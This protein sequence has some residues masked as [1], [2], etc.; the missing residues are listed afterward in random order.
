MD[1]SNLMEVKDYLGHANSILLSARID[2]VE[3]IIEEMENDENILDIIPNYIVRLDSIPEEDTYSD[4][5]LWG[6]NNNGLTLI[7]STVSNNTP[8][9]ET[10]NPDPSEVDPDIQVE[11]AWDEISNPDSVVVAVLDTGIDYNH[12]DL[13]ENMWSPS[14]DCYDDENNVI[15]GGCPNHGWDFVNSDNNPSDDSGHGTHVAGIIGAENNDN[16]IVGVNWNIEL[17]SVKCFD[18]ESSLSDIAD[19]LNAIEFAQNNEAQVINASWSIIPEDEIP[20]LEDKIEDFV[21]A[22]GL[23]VTSS[24][25]NGQDLGSNPLYPNVYDLDGAENDN[26]IVV[27]ATDQA[28]EIASFSNWGDTE[29]DIAAPGTNILSTSYSGFP[30]YEYMSGTS[31]S[32]PFVTGVASL[33]WGISPNLTATQVKSIILENSDYI[34]DLDVST[35][36]HPISSS[37]RLNA[38]RAIVAAKQTPT[39]HSV[40]GG[41]NWSSTATWEEGRVPDENDWVEINGTVSLNANSQE[42]RGIYVT[43]GST[44]RPTNTDRTI[45]VNGDLENDGTITNNGSYEITFNIAGNLKNDG[46]IQDSATKFYV[47]GDIENNSTFS[48]LLYLTGTDTHEF[49][50]TTAIYKLSVTENATISGDSYFTLIDVD[51]SYTLTQDSES[52]ISVSSTFINDGTISGGEVNFTGASSQSLYGAGTYTVSALNFIGSGTKTILGNNSIT[53][54]IAIISGVTLQPSGNTRTFTV[55]GDLTNNGTIT[56]YS[57]YGLIFDV[58][59]NITNTGTVNNYLVVF[60]MDG[61]WTSTGTMDGMLHLTGSSTQNYTD[62]TIQEKIYAD[63]NVSVNGDITTINIEVASGKTLTLE[64]GSDLDIYNECRNNGTIS[65]GDLTFVGSGGSMYGIGT[66]NTD[67]LTFGG[68]GTKYIYADQAINSDI[69]VNSG[70]YVKSNSG[71]RTIYITGDITNNGYIQK[72]DIYTDLNLYINGNIDNDGTMTPTVAYASWATIP[73]A[74]TYEFKLKTDETWGDAVSTGTNTFYNITNYL[75]GDHE[76]QFQGID[77]TTPLGWSESKYIN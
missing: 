15:T 61:D 30:A 4:G 69:T 44:L 46:T 28:D 36:T 68:T 71:D 25:N 14:G 62:A 22:G 63:D 19:V 53:G 57:S 23:F 43:S 24:G 42:V 27:A 29:A 76:W 50:G 67:S 64:N 40:V 45:T 21:D 37:G 2:V 73:E 60:Y 41:G 47:A 35:G 55:D 6:L 56:Y 54:D 26:M 34:A 66:Y 33:I 16:G 1:K 9:Y 48:S 72:K 75:T 51:P 52:T 10:N 32:A 70:V 20:V 59:G 31:M 39:I 12:T 18:E 11:D 7:Q 3:E 49:S 38:Y 13:D 17:M 74:D 8:V 65:G 58:T 5:Y 77:D